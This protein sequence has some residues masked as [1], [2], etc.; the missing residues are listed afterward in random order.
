MQNYIKVISFTGCPP[1]GLTYR[2][3]LLV[4]LR[5]I[6][7]L[8]WK[9]EILRVEL[10]ELSWWNFLKPVLY[11]HF[12]SA[13]FN[14]FFPWVTFLDFPISCAQLSIKSVTYLEFSLLCVLCV[15][16]ENIIEE[17]FWLLPTNRP[18]HIVN[19]AYLVLLFLHSF[20]LLQVVTWN[21][22][23]YTIA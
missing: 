6:I 14:C 23:S 3:D 12:F 18:I 16:C 19:F 10:T 22:F 17:H 13:F 7:I 4:S 5:Q 2:T 9:Y 1:S 20:Q 11:V 21:T 8:L 15:N